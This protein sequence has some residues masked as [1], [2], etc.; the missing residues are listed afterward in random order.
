MKEVMNEYG[1]TIIAAV[2]TVLVISL[3]FVAKVFNGENILEG[4]GQL[5]MSMNAS[6]FDDAEASDASYH[7]ALGTMD[8]DSSDVVANPALVAGTDYTSDELVGS[9]SGDNSYSVKVLN[10]SSMAGTDD[11]CDITGDVLKNGVVRFDRNGIYKIR[12][13]C[14]DKE[15]RY[16]YGNMFMNVSQQKGVAA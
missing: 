13:R 1:R 6:E 7:A 9:K 2:A 15:G 5:A 12:M 3:L 16:F 8:F 14:T 11:G 4:T 10:V